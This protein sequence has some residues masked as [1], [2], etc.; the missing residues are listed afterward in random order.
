MVVIP[1][2]F[3]ISKLWFKRGFRKSISN[4]ITRF[5]SNAVIAAKFMATKVLPSPEMVEVM[6]ITVF[7]LLAKENSRFVRNERK[8]SLTIE[9]SFFSMMSFETSASVL[10]FG[11]I[12]TIGTS[13]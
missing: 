11:M 12:P 5:P 7:L 2:E 8:A 10:I 6:E 13:V 1:S 9:L 4:K 3:E